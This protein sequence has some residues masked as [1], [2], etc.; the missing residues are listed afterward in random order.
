MY[1]DEEETTR[2]FRLLRQM[3]TEQGL[4]AVLFATRGTNH[5]FMEEFYFLQ[6]DYIPALDSVTLVAAGREPVTATHRLQAFSH[7]QRAAVADI[8][9]TAPNPADTVIQLLLEA[10]IRS[11]RVGMRLIT[12]PSTW[13]RQF[14]AALPDVEWVD[15]TRPLLDILYQ[16]SAVELAA[17]VESAAIADAGYR[18]VLD[19]IE[20]GMTEFDVVAEFEHATVRRGANKNFT[21]I[22][23]GPMRRGAAAPELTSPSWRKIEPGDAVTLEMSPAVSGYYTQLVRTVLVGEADSYVDELR[24]VCVDAIT[25]AREVLRPG[26]TISEVATVIMD[27]VRDSGM[28]PDFPI[29]HTVGVNLVYDRLQPDIDRRLEENDVLI[30]HPRIL[31]ADGGF[32][33]FWGETYGVTAGGNQRLHQ[34]DDAVH[35]TREHVAVSR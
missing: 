3:I 30:I 21:L 25:A 35:S 22:A 27:S 32:A 15:I 4:D 8:R 7:R 28:T 24:Q 5:S 29:G 12:L 11:G 23:S 14:Q 13:Y 16:K 9:E 2:R 1:F 6:N 17:A 34:S 10:G 18:H 33:F 31:S 26:I 19:V 20:P